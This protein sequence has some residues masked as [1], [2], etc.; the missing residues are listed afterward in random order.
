MAVMGC[1]FRTFS[2]VNPGG[3]GER[4]GRGEEWGEAPGRVR[5]IYALTAPSAMPAMNCFAPM[6]NTRM[7]GTTAMSAEA[8][9]MP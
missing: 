5:P 3:E 2:Y 6:M 4:G 9:S 1:E 7:S 8:I